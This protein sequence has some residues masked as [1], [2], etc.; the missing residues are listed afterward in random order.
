MPHQR[1][2]SSNNFY[3]H[4]GYL[5]NEDAQA[6]GVCCQAAPVEGAGQITGSDCLNDKECE[7]LPQPV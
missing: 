4:S 7:D 6:D 5:F 2:L 1:S 3:I